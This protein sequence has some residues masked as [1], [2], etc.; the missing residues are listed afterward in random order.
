VAASIPTGI[1]IAKSPWHLARMRLALALLLLAAASPARAQA[2]GST[3]L[4]LGMDLRKAPVGAWSEYAVSVAELP[5]M[6]QRFAVVARDAATHSVE[7]T[8]EGGPL[9]RQRMVLQFVLE[10]DPAKKDRV[11]R[12][13]I[14]LG[15]ND[16]MELPPG[17]AQFL[18]PKKQ[19]G[20]AKVKVPAG[21]FA[22][23]HYR[24]KAEDGS[25]M[26]VWVSDQAPP[27]GIVKLVGSTNE[28]KSPVSMA[29]SAR[30]SDAKP[31]ITKPPQPFNQDVLTGQMKRAMEGK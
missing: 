6:K 14:Q 13:V 9:G 29:L 23:R 3:P 15:D 2:P 28:G 12:S 27:F 24:D 5:P 10:A 17:S 31:L 1:D 18:P 30:G 20:A 26:E 16:P 22:T 4:P 11:R 21:S 19:V 7:V 25:V 8:S